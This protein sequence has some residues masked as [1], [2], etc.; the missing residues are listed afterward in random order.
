[1]MPLH[2]SDYLF[3]ILFQPTWNTFKYCAT[4]FWRL[5]N[6]TI[7]LSTVGSLYIYTSGKQTNLKC[8]IEQNFLNTWYFGSIESL[9]LLPTLHRIS[10]LHID[11]PTALMMNCILWRSLTFKSQSLEERNKHNY[12]SKP[13]G[14]V[15]SFSWW[16]HSCFCQTSKWTNISGLPLINLHPM[17]SSQSFLVLKLRL[18]ALVSN[19]GTSSR[20]N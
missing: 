12:Q 1:M 19:K 8:R 2:P 10:T 9:V 17:M 3:L 5:P 16:F 14:T 15:I 7:T 11:L 4:R 20:R 18:L 13:P 6:Q